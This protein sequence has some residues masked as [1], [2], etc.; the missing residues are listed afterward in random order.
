MLNKQAVTAK[1]DTLRLASDA[2]YKTMADAR[3]NYPYYSTNVVQSTL[4]YNNAN[5]AYSDYLNGADVDRVLAE[6]Q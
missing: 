6:W 5:D 3:R 2:A 4:M 1:L